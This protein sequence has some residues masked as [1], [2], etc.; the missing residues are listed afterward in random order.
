MA[1]N[2]CGRVVETGWIWLGT[3]NGDGGRDRS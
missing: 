3:M 1:N 2:G